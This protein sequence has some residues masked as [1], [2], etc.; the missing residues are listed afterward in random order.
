MSLL[1]WRAQAS[2]PGDARRPSMSAPSRA[3]EAHAGDAPA[4]AP[5]PMPG[6]V[7]LLELA[8]ARDAELPPPPWGALLY[9]W[10]LFAW[11]RFGR[12]ASWRRAVLNHAYL[13]SD[14]SLSAHVCF[15]FTARRPPGHGALS[16]LDIAAAVVEHT[17][18][19]LST[20]PALGEVFS[21]KR[22]SKSRRALL[23]PRCD[24]HVQIAPPAL[25]AVN[26]LVL[27]GGH[28]FFYTWRGEGVA[29]VRATLG[30][31]HA[32]A[33]RLG[34]AAAPLG[35]LSGL[36]R[37]ARLDSLRALRGSP[38]GDTYLEWSRTAHF[39]LSLELDTF[40]SSPGQLLGATRDGPLDS[41]AFEQVL[42]I[43]AHGDGSLGF[44]WEHSVIDG[45]EAKAITEALLAYPASAPPPAGTP[46]RW[47]ILGT[48]PLDALPELSAL[49]HAARR[50]H[51]LRRARTSDTAL[52]LSVEGQHPVYSDLAWAISCAARQL[53]L[54][55][56]RIHEAVS[57]SH[58]AHG[59]YD[60]SRLPMGLEA[61][62]DFIA[63]HRRRLGGVKQEQ[64]DY[65]PLL[66][67]SAGPLPP[68]WLSAP[69]I[70]DVALSHVGPSPTLDGFAFHDDTAHQIGV[71]VI[72]R[73][74][75]LHLHV[76]AVGELQPHLDAF[77]EGLL[78][79]WRSLAVA[80]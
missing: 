36:P 2:A 43:I 38:V 28:H 33:G 46:A 27:C 57:M 41:R 71:A 21:Q 51:A 3:S 69:S 7:R 44:L 74:A 42:Q 10:Y 55:A 5:A 72:S 62:P 40:P 73:G 39:S 66:A 80:P 24:E 75:Q 16:A 65:L 30:A 48:A 13:S 15:A 78:R 60:T 54:P 61:R 34:P 68:R 31:M 18:R 49:L 12:A 26:V 77:V 79:C 52:T 25:E 45:V 76:Y 29:E 58:L 59:R 50:Q 47:E 4:A 14:A 11:L 53:G 70:A 20:T 32:H 64:N 37:G 23:A 6:F 9:P 56:L 19:R 8:R 22:F 35:A 67:M 17:A 63:E 1:R